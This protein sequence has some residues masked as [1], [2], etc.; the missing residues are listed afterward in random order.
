MS[1]QQV[2]K[3]GVGSGAVG[4][5]NSGGAGGGVGGAGAGSAG[6]GGAGGGSA[7]PFPCQAIL[8]QS[9]KF[10]IEQDRPVLF[11]YYVDTATNKACMMEDTESKNKILFKS[12]DEYTSYVQKVYKVAD[13]YMILTENSIYIVSGK[14]TKRRVNL[15]QI[16]GDDDE[17]IPV[18]N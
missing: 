18:S 11:D 12:R 17:D 8:V 15:K 10:A 9:A 13:D 16:T 3:T 5:G 14:I 1:S 6:A 4:A 2:N 7:D